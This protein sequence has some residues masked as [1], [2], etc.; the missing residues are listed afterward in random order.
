MESLMADLQPLNSLRK[1][2][3]DLNGLTSV[4][5]ERNAPALRQCE[6]KLLSPSSQSS[7]SQPDLSC[8]N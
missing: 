8:T 1:C 3:V 7:S 2:I 6:G 4:I 5:Y